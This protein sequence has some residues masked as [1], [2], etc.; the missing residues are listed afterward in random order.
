MS[1]KKYFLALLSLFMMN[2]IRAGNEETWDLERCIQYAVENNIQIQKSNV[3]EQQQEVS[4]KEAQAALFPSLSFGMNQSLNYRPLQDSPNS[5]V[6]N[7]MAN[8]SVKKLTENGNY[9]LNASWTVWDGKSNTNTIKIQKLNK[10]MAELDT[11]ISKNSITEQITQ[12]YIQI[13]YSTEAKKVNESILE[14]AK[15]QV[16]RGK[17]MM[18][19]GLLSETELKQLEAQ[20]SSAQYDVVNAQTQID[21]YNLQLKQ[22]LELD[23]NTDFQIA[24]LEIADEQALQ[25]V[26]SSNEVYSQALLLRPEIQSKQT[27]I[28]AAKLSVDVAK[29]GYQP[30]L[31][32]NAS[33]SD[34]HYST[35]AQVASQLKE[36]L[37]G[38]IGLT[39]SVPI[40]DNRKNKSA[41]ERAKLDQVTKALEL[42]EEQKNLYNTI[43]SYNL[44]ARNNQEKFKASITKTESM[45]SSYKLLNEQFE[46]G[47]KN[48]VELLTGKD[49]LLQAQ[50]EKL[51]SKYTTLLNIQLLKFYQG[52]SM[53]L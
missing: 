47:L 2:N 30:S 17:E 34:S 33:I 8:T 35:G 37:N 10:K 5:I 27:A 3:S 21:D 49:D 53:T 12:L 52:N 29:A 39:L 38:S 9:S 22:L 7:G 14:T 44:Q 13:L 25:L 19:N 40:F 50:Q 16:E 4:L 43:E 51:Q 48:V 24:D 1:K 28:E 45:E 23:P 31:S 36:N 6:A 32:L 11:E 18:Q 15:K 42:T 41:V 26:P 46:N 20:W